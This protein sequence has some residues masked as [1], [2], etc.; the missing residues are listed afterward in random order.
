MK[1]RNKTSILL[2]LLTAV[3]VWLKVSI[4]GLAWAGGY[5]TP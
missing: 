4:F 2:A 1:I 3:S 5:G